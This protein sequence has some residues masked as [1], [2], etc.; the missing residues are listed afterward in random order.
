MI[1]PLLL[2]PMMIN[3]IFIEELLFSYTVSLSELWFAII[4]ITSRS[5]ACLRLSR[6]LCI[7]VYGLIFMLVAAVVEDEGVIL[8]V[9]WDL[10]IWMHILLSRNGYTFKLHIYPP[11]PYKFKQYYQYK[12]WIGIKIWY[13][14]NIKVENE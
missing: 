9:S 4:I 12:K 2:F 7:I 1:M 6:G 3:S 11:I 8:F 13:N 10:H 5:L 14:G